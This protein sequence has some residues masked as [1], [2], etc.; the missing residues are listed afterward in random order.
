[1]LGGG[2][3]KV[4]LTSPAVEKGRLGRLFHA[5]HHLPSLTVGPRDINTPQILQPQILQ[6][7]RGDKRL[8]SRRL[9][10]L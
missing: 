1:M 2:G 7:Q 5:P 9:H 8:S 4:G 10:S 6:P 3:S